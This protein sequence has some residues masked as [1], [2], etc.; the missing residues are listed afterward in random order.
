MFTEV[1]IAIAGFYVSLQSLSYTNFLTI[2]WLCGV[3]FWTIWE[4]LS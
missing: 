2:A 3:I 1:M 4:I